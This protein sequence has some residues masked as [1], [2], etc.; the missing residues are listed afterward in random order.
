MD[1]LVIDIVK[2]QS[3][4]TVEQLIELIKLRHSIAE[5]EILK[6]ILS[7]ESQGEIALRKERPPP[8]TL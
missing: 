6:H 4:S 8:P 5:E 2:N 1:Q 7:L 3:P